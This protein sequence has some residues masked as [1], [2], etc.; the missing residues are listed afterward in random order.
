MSRLDRI[1]TIGTV[2]MLGI[3][4]ISTGLTVRAG[5][6]RNNSAASPLGTSAPPPLTS[7]RQWTAVVMLSSTCEYCNQSMPIFRSI[8]AGGSA[9]AVVVAGTESA[10]SLRAYSESHGFKADRYV[11]L[12]TAAIPVRVTPAMLLVDP[13]GVIRGAW[14]GQPTPNVKRSMIKAIAAV[15]K[16]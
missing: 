1:L 7:Q 2:L 8:F 11:T 4:I 10:E 3:G 13:S 5:M 15:A 12:S 6:Q 9:L 16:P 14:M